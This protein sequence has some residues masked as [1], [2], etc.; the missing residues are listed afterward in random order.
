VPC[1]RLAGLPDWATFHD[2]RHSYASLL[3][4]QRCLVKTIQR[5]LGNESATE[6]LDTCGHL[7]PGSDDETRQAVDHVLSMLRGR[8]E[9]AGG[10]QDAL[11]R[12][13]RRHSRVAVGC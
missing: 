8:P 7:W 2:L 13:F 11:K 6:T 3:I 1:A 4:A 5:R 10:L 9:T 12:S